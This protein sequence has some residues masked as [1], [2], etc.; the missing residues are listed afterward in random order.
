M[1]RPPRWFAPRAPMNAPSR[2]AILPRGW[3]LALLVFSILLLVLGV[4][5]WMELLLSHAGETSF[6]AV[7]STFDCATVWSAPAAKRIQALTQLPVAGWGVAYAMVA[8]LLS[9]YVVFEGL[10]G[11]VATLAL[12]ASRWVGAAGLLGSLGLFLVT[13]DMGVFCITCL[14]T[15]GLILGY[16]LAAFM[17]GRALLAGTPRL[18]A[19]ELGLPAALL[20]ASYLAL[21]L[22]A[23]RT[24][25]GPSEPA[26]PELPVATLA[27]AAPTET[28]EAP[29]AETLA[30][31][32][33]ETPKAPEAPD[34]PAPQ[35]AARPKPAEAKAPAPKKA[36]T[37]QAL[38]RFL[39]SLPTG[40]Q[41]LV[42]KLLARMKRAPRPD[43]SAY[44]PRAPTGGG[45]V[46]IVDFSDVRCPHCAH[47]RETLDELT[48]KLP[49]RFTHESRYYPLDAECNSQLGPRMTDGTGV[50][51]VGA[52]ALICAAGSRQ[53]HKFKELVFKNQN[54][55]DIERIF[56]LAKQAG[57]DSTE[58]ERCVTEA[59]TT[60]KLN[61][62]IAYASAYGIEGTP[63]VLVNGQK[64]SN[65]GPLLYALILAKGDLSDPAFSVLP[66]AEK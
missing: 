56:S 51:C 45:P 42:S 64:A 26:L 15:Y 3:M 33:A 20:L 57:L 50:R 9:L 44:P 40:E 47:L 65:Y 59:G 38:K 46:H 4:F 48:T 58:I 19:K 49:G 11:R 53:A 55:L 32:K 66:A 30:A 18:W 7:N 27:P 62:D 63:M 10:A 21:L 39:S 24:P 17:L 34:K 6:C 2:P 13:V 36:S 1:R 14:T 12:A 31:P 22:P 41:Q 29:K 5:Q 35:A 43:T 60:A 16:A 52:K 28:H 54:R 37:E 23:S 8:S 25:M 61:Q